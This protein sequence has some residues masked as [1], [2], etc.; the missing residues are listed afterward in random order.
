[1][2]INKS[3]PSRSFLAIGPEKVGD[4]GLIL[5]GAVGRLAVFLLTAVGLFNIDVLAIPVNAASD[6]FQLAP[7]ERPLPIVQ[8]VAG[9]D[10]LDSHRPFS[11]DAVST[12]LALQQV[13]RVPIKFGK[14]DKVG[15]IESQP[16]TSRSDAKDSDSRIG[17]VLKLIAKHLPVLLRSPTVDSDIVRLESVADESANTVQ[18]LLVVAKDNDLEMLVAFINLFEVFRDRRE[19]RAT[20]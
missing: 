4:C 15:L 10:V 13:S 17:I 6:D 8:R 18:D 1:M 9:D 3:L 11:P 19:L 12:I 5:G 7:D 16:N 2:R 14:D 20:S